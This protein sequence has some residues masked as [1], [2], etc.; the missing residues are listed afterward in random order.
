MP[1]GISTEHLLAL[2][3]RLLAADPV[4]PAELAHAAIDAL[5]D[6]LREGS[7]RIRDDCTALDAATDAVL[8]FSKQPQTYDPSRLTPWAYLRMAA[9]RNLANTLR[10]ESRHRNRILRFANVALHGAAGNK[11]VASPSTD[12]ADQE[13]ARVRL[14]ALSAGPICAMPAEDHAVL[15]LIAD[16]ERATGPFAAILGIT[17]QP[18]HEQRRRVKQAKDRV[19]KRLTRSAPEE[20]DG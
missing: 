15:R 3:R 19:L 6:E 16:G 9:R 7:R 13:R 10:K 18:E 1:G 4:A 14:D 12:L 20:L 17:S 5:A 2:H 8:E 11:E